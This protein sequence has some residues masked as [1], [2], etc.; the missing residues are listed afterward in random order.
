MSSDTLHRSRAMSAAGTAYEPGDV[1][2]F[3]GITWTVSG[4]IEITAD[5]FVWHE[6][7]LVR[8]GG[9]TRAGAAHAAPA[10]AGSAPV[11]AGHAHSVNKHDGARID[12]A[13]E[14]DETSYDGEPA[15]SPGNR[16]WVTVETVDGVPTWSSWGR[17]RAVDV[18]VGH[19]HAHDSLFIEA[20]RGHARY[21]VRGDI[22]DL[23]IP[24]AGTLTY[25]D[26]DRPGQR[27]SLER[28]DSDDRC[29][30]AG[31]WW[32]SVCDLP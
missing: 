5:R 2:A 27:V 14:I 16:A 17:R 7:L 20:E 24:P 23:L 19:E 6:Y 28:F 13:I 3:H 21:R 32:L 4:G 29:E 25:I 15:E 9:R 31:G 10:H 30:G 22:G 8:N 26:Y 1:V 11:H 12:G 18:N